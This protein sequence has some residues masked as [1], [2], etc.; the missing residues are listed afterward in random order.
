LEG[1]VGTAQDDSSTLSGVKIV[2]KNSEAVTYTDSDGKFKLKS[3]L[4]H[5]VVLFSFIG[6]E[7]LEV[8][9]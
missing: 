4:E 2:I 3:S 7:P 5:G 6:F 9:F 8:K 1:A